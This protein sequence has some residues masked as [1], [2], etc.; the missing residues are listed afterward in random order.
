MA[1]DCECPQ[2]KSPYKSLYI[3]RVL[4]YWTKLVEDKDFLKISS[5]MYLAI[6]I[7][8][9]TDH[10]KLDWLRNIETLLCSLGFSGIWQSQ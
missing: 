5:Q 10:L 3:N 6:H 4:S 1:L 7:L 2:N 8:H 9:K